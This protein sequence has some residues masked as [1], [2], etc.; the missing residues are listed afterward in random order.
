MMVATITTTLVAVALIATTLVAV[1]AIGI[2]LL[3]VCTG[4]CV[5]SSSS[6]GQRDRRHDQ[7]S[8]DD[9]RKGSH[10]S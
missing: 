5:A 3:G 1:A 4:E 6:I 8:T 9:D 2:P 10:P 7:R